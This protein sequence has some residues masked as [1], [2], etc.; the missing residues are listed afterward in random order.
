MVVTKYQERIT[1]TVRGP[2][3]RA[4]HAFCP[5][6]AE[7]FGIQFKA[8]TFMPSLPPRM[9]MDRCDLNLPEAVNQRF[10]LC[11]SAWQFP[12][13]ENADTFVSRLARDEV[14]IHDPVVSSVLEGKPVEP[15]LRTVQRRVMQAT[16][17]SPN[18]VRQIVRARY[19]TVL[20]KN[21]ISILDVVFL[22][23]YADQPHLTRS[24]RQMIGQTPAQIMGENRT[25]RL[26]FLFNTMPI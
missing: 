22:A 19:A 1:L 7:F 18:R 10:W 8:G 2:E 21:G 25:E 12:D 5:P 26:S 15:S 13:F 4:T 23:G 11:S 17:L 14:L 9:V 20:L 6:D 24:L 3:T 16:G